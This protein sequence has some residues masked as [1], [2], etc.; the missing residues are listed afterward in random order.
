MNPYNDLQLLF[1][2]TSAL[3]GRV[4]DQRDRQAIVAI[5]SHITSRPTRPP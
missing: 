4:L 1:L 5:Y 3:L 2:F